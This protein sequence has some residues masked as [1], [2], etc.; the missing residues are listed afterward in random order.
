[1]NLVF[2]VIFSKLLHVLLSIF[3]LLVYLRISFVVYPGFVE[4]MLAIALVG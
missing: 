1:M 3:D 2:Y 4:R